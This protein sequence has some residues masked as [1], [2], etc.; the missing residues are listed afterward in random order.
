M[1]QEL[2]GYFGV[3]IGELAADD[4]LVRLRLVEIAAGLG[5]LTEEVVDEPLGALVQVLEVGGELNGGV[6]AEM[7]R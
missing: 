7:R 3:G 1:L 5:E 4:D 6:S 2:I